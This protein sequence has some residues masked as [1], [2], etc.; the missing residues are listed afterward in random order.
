MDGLKKLVVIGGGCA[1]LV[2]SVVSFN[3]GFD[4]KGGGLRTGGGAQKQTTG[5]R[6]EYYYDKNGNLMKKT[7]TWYMYK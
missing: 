1:V 7:T 6:Y 5:Q 4:G 2:Y 3:K